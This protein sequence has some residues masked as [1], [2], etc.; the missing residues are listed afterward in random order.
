M[1]REELKQKALSLP[2]SP[3]VYIMRNEEGAVIYV[4]KSRALKNRVSQYFVNLASHTSKTRNMVRQIDHFDYILADSEFEALVLE[5]SLIKRHQPRYN[6][7][8]KDGKGYPYV[9]LSVDHSYPRFSLVNQVK[10]D[11][12]RYFGPYGS[13]SS[14][15]EILRAISTALR[16]PTCRKTFPRDIGKDRPCLNHHLGNCDGWCRP[17]M[18][19]EAY[20]A[21]IQQAIRL[22]DGKFSEV[23]K[24]LEQEMFRASEELRFEQAAE[25][26]DRLQAIRLLGVRQK[27]VAGIQAETDV[28]GIYQSQ[29]KFSFT[30]LHYLEGTLAERDVELLTMPVE[31]S[32]GEAL[33]ALLKQYYGARE[34]LPKVIC[35]PCDFEDR[36]ELEQLLTQ[37]A[38]RK[39]ELLVP[40]RG[41]KA[42]MVRLANKNAQEELERQV[43]KEER[44]HQLLTLFGSMLGLDAT[45][46]RIE[47][48]DISN[49]GS[50]D[51]VGGMTVFV[52]G[53]P[54]K[55]AYRKFHLKDLHGPDDYASMDQVLTRRFRR[56]L[57][58]NE[59]FNV[60][61]DV[62]LMDGGLGQVGIACRVLAQAGLEVPVF[63]MVKDGRHRT[64]ALVAPDGREIGLQAQPAIFA[65]VGR[66]QEETH[67]YAITFH[68]ASHNKR[69]VASA[70]E[71]IPGVGEVRRKQLL[72][73]FKSVKAIRE[74][75]YEELCQA[76][77]KSV[78]QAVYTHF[79]GTNGELEGGT[80]T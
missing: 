28:V 10:E 48:Y 15:R 12:A 4:G 62:I 39:V 44:K 6:I 5:C 41:N 43:T 11:G 13:R 58:G 52:D 18:T 3:G 64:R 76:V 46:H 42:N 27:V 66:I 16:L 51:I 79:H 23:E 57:E 14:T 9:R 33:S 53:K 45:P 50:D 2:L 77:P 20:R 69:T 78:A 17:E 80:N 72:K 55:S 70:L 22:L 38:G 36:A 30:V 40:K 73:R 26:R 1:T 75:D 61:P 21:R 29:L 65:L 31:E 68:H 24:E 19:E 56:Y 47:A 67:R 32:G 63:G 37:Q 54:L 74:A 60:L 8:L 49:T 7:L 59:K 71:A 25:L 35:L 34:H